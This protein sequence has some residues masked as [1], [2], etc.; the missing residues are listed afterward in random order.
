[1]QAA[2][3]MTQFHDAVRAAETPGRM[4]KVLLR[5]SDLP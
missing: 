5:I 1:V 2:F 3:A 4:G